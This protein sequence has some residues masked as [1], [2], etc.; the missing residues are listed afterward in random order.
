MIWENRDLR[1]RIELFEKNDEL[2][3]KEKEL[4]LLKKDL[5]IEKLKN[6]LLK[7]VE[8]LEEKKPVPEI[9]STLEIL[10][11]DLAQKIIE[12]KESTLEIIEE[13]DSVPE[14]L[15]EEKNQPIKK[16][17]L[18]TLN[19]DYKCEFCNKYYS[20]KNNLLNHQK[21]T[22]K[23]LEKQNKVASIIFACKFCNKTFTINQSLEYHLENTCK[24]KFQKVKRK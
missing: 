13:N 19:S 8:I 20:S 23:C 6:S 7:K 9:E 24:K 17:R 11:K 10:E 3:K 5:E 2:L 21:T 14:I 1:H 4:G 18:Q 12:E 22:L 16:G 15:E